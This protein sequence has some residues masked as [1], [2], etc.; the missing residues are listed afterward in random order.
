MPMISKGLDKSIAQ[1]N[2]ATMASQPLLE[3]RFLDVSKDH[4]SWK[5][6]ID[7]TRAKATKRLNIL[8]S[9][10]GT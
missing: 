4:K 8:K 5:K 9:L 7:E 3:N 1:N 2:I 10:E 6:H